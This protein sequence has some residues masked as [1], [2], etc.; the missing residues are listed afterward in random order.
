MDIEN[1]IHPQGVD[2][3]GTRPMM[4]RVHSFKRAPDFN[5]QLM[6]DRIVRLQFS[7]DKREK[8]IA[9]KIRFGGLSKIFFVIGECIVP[10]FFSGIEQ[11]FLI[12]AGVSGG[13]ECFQNVRVIESE[14][15]IMV[16][17]SQFM[18]NHEWMFE[19]LLSGK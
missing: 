17:M 11:D 16:G 14:E 2:A 15:L 19:H 5:Q 8:I 1:K 10:H 18:K 12:E 7:P 13:L 4:V 3:P 6:H 9:V